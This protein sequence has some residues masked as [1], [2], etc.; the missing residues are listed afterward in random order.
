MYIGQLATLTGCTPKAI[1]LYE[2]LG[3]LAEPK[4]RGRYRVYDAHDADV[5]RLIR[6][7]L[8]VGF[9]LSEL[10]GLIAEKHR[11]QRFPIERANEEIE[12]KRRQV[13]ARL[14]ELQAL[15]ASLDDRPHDV[16]SQVAVGPRDQAQSVHVVLSFPRRAAGSLPQW[17]RPVRPDVH[18]R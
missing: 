12:A 17:Q 10:R 6:A 15:D 7:S 9:K 1:R 13:R 8:S 16:V 14:Q 3:L 5:V 4:R 11:L 18:G 2:S